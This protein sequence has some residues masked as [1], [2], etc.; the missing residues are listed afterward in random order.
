MKHA[1]CTLHDSAIRP[2]CYTDLL[3]AVRYSLLMH[4][5]IS[6]AHSYDFL[7]HEFHSIVSANAFNLLSPLLFEKNIIFCELRGDLNLFSQ[8]VSNHKT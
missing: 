2:F 7:V 5:T 3:G 1:S 8:E 6:G 4:D